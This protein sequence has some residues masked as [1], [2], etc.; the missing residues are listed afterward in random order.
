VAGR[1]VVWTIV[2]VAMLGVGAAAA[3]GQYQPQYQ[4]LRLDRSHLKWGSPVPGTGT[5]VT[6]AF[7]D[8]ALH[9]PA[10]RNCRDLAPMDGLLARSGIDRAALEREAAAAFAM[11]E[12]VADIGFRRVDDPDAA[13]IV[14]GA[15]A[16]PRGVAFAD[17]AYDRAAGGRV[18]SLRRSLICLNPQ[19]M[20]KIGFGGGVTVYDLRFG[21]AHEIG[22]AIG[23]DHPSPSG[24]LMSFRYDE[25]VR[26][27]QAG[28][29]AGVVALYGPRLGGA[30][31]A[32]RGSAGE[33]ASDPRPESGCPVPAAPE[34]GTATALAAGDVS[35]AGTAEPAF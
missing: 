16:E 6:Y 7:A 14:I 5:T 4:W 2:A 26:D 30:R 33:I 35:C 32:A 18:R 12:S 25:K 3:T 19:Q 29:I 27:L 22:H 24:Q 8:R 28:D 23:L 1:L 21:I 20:W 15:Q 13:Q 34:P 11:W 31:T 17:V 9:S 10:S